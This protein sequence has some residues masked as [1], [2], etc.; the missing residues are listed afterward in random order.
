MKTKFI[1]ILLLLSLS[2]LSGCATKAPSP[3]INLSS[4]SAEDRATLEQLIAAS[5]KD[6]DSARF[7]GKIVIVNGK[8]ACVEVNAKNSFGGY[9]GFQQAMLVKFSGSSVWTFISVKD[10]NQELCTYVL[11][12]K[13][14]KNT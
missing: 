2:I 3:P 5:L 4:P 12:K 13:V 8:A 6:P 14:N 1:P 10:I 7:S 11:D 9:T